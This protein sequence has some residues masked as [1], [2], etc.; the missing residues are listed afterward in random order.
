MT[1]NATPRYDRVLILLSLLF[2]LGIFVPIMPLGMQ[3]ASAQP[4]TGTPAAS[5]TPTVFSSGAAPLPPVWRLQQQAVGVYSPSDT[6]AF[7]YRT[8]GSSAFSCQC[9]PTA[10]ATRTPTHPPSLATPTSTVDFRFSQHK[11]AGTALQA[12]DIHSPRPAIL[13][14]PTQSGDNCSVG[15]DSLFVTGSRYTGSFDTEEFDKNTSS[16]KRLSKGKHAFVTIQRLLDGQTVRIG[17]FVAD[18]T[19]TN[20][21]KLLRFCYISD[22]PGSPSEIYQGYIKGIYNVQAGVRYTPISLCQSCFDNCPPPFQS[23]LPARVL[24]FWSPDWST[25]GDPLRGRQETTSGFLGVAGLKGPGGCFLTRP[26][27]KRSSRK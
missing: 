8:F 16:M 18:S 10:T 22:G 3:T 13:P 15:P 27:G 23:N 9:F 2:F 17:G 25:Y 4:P 12:S 21:K 1:R 11:G 20:A 14:T 24:C 7:G 26:Y 5:P 19:G 6:H